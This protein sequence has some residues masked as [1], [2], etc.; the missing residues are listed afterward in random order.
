MRKQTSQSIPPTL[1][2]ELFENRTN[3]F[4]VKLNH[5]FTDFAEDR[6]FGFAS[7][8]SPMFAEDIFVPHRIAKRILDYNMSSSAKLWAEVSWNQEGNKNRYRIEFIWQ[9]INDV[10]TKAK[11]KHIKKAASAIVELQKSLESYPSSS[12]TDFAENVYTHGDHLSAAKQQQL[13][14]RL[15]SIGNP[16]KG[17][18]LHNTIAYT[19][20]EYHVET[21]AKQ[22][23][24]TVLDY[25]EANLFA[26]QDYK[27]DGKDIDV[28]SVIGVGRRHGTQYS[29]FSV[30]NEILVGVYTHTDKLNDDVIELSIDGVFD[31]QQYSALDLPLRYLKL[32]SAPNV[33]YFSSIERY[34][35]PKTN[36][37]STPIRISAA[38]IL[39]SASN[40]SFPQL[41]E[42]CTKEQCEVLLE[43]LITKQNQTLISTIVELT[44]KDRIE[45]FAH[46]LA[47][48]IIDKTVQKQVIDTD[49]IEMLLGCITPIQSR[50]RQLILDL[51]QANQTLKLVRCHWHP[52]ETI[53]EMGI[54]IYYADT[55]SVP[56]LKAVCDCN[57]RLKTTF[58]T[59]S[60]KTN[61]TLCYRHDDNICDQLNC[62]CL[63]HSYRDYKLG[64]I[65]L[66]K[67]SC[68]KYGKG[69]YDSWILAEKYPYPLKHL[70]LTSTNNL[71][72][73]EI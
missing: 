19:Y 63:L 17:W 60:W 24:L 56:T 41:L 25:N 71:S 58:F 12:N 66:G 61:Q 5:D 28:K 3:L 20:S 21:W 37:S 34:F 14:T 68:T 4:E 45:L 69:S 23:Q 13:Q 51:L 50:Q 73:I 32:R 10:A 7:F 53:R 57:P 44:N 33:C 40:G 39:H 1:F 43:K 49:N 65:I 22:H 26:P 54:D 38:L 29:S 30:D 59:Y 9:Q 47:D 62:G 8:C 70:T 48:Y 46:Y 72:D 36:I 64:N 6:G 2:H 27:I 15:N 31:P 67:S 55:S 16:K 35:L 11:P 18:D 52:E 42:A